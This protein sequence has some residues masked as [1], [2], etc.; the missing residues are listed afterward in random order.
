MLP[1]VPRDYFA[2]DT[3]EAAGQDEVEFSHFRATPRAIDEHS[4][5][6][7]ACRSWGARLGTEGLRGLR[8]GRIGCLA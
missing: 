1:R 7:L 5:A 8:S 2:P 3:M 4:V 6:S